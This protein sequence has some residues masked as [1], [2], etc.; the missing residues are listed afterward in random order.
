MKRIFILL[1]TVFLA[2]TVFS[3]VAVNNS[4]NAADAS[5]MLDVSSTSKGMLVPRMTTSQRT[6][7]SSPATGLLVFDTSTKSF[8][9]YDAG[10]SGWME[11]KASNNNSTLADADEDTKV[12]V[13]KTA[14]NDMISFSQ[15][16][17]EYF[18]MK[19]GR[20]NIENTGSSVF[21]GNLAGEHDNLSDN[22]NVFVGQLA[23]KENTSGDYNVAV[24]AVSFSTNTTG[25][26]NVALGSYALS[27]SPTASKNVAVGSYALYSDSADYNVALGYKALN[28]NTT[29][30]AN[31]AGGYKALFWNTSGKGNVAIGKE[32]LF[33]NSNNSYLVAIGDSALMNNYGDRN[34]AVGSKAMLY[35]TSGND[36]TAV[37]FNSLKNNVNGFHNTAIGDSS[38]YNTT[39]GYYNTAVGSSSLFTNNAGICN[40]AVGYQAMKTNFD[41]EK[42]VAV[43]YKSLYKNTSGNNNTAVGYRVMEKNTRGESNIAMGY[44]AMFYN[45]T[46][47]YNIAIGSNALMGGSAPNE[48]V[49]IGKD[50]ALGISTGEGNT[51]VGSLSLRN[52]GAGIGNVGIG[53]GA[54]YG[55]SSKN[56]NV[57]IGDSALFDGSGNN[58]TGIGSKVLRNN[59][60]SNN[61]AL[62][63]QAG[64]SN[65]TGSSNIFIGYQAGYNETGSNKLYI[66]NS[67]S[68]SPLIYGDFA[69]DTLKVF[70]TF[71]IKDRYSFP[72]ADGSANQVLK[73]NG[74]GVLSWSNDTGATEINGLSDGKTG[75]KSV[76]LGTDAGRV[77]DGSDNKNTAVGYD[78]LYNNTT[79]EGNTGLGEEALFQNTSGY[80]NVGIGVEANGNNQTGNFNT[81]IGYQAG[82]GT[83]SHNKSGCVLIGY[84]AGYNETGNNKLYIEN[85]NSSSPL[86]YGEF[87][88][89][90][91]TINGRLGIG[92]NAGTDSKLRVF[93][94]G[95]YA[96]YFT[97][98]YG[99][100]DTKVLKV[101]YT[102]PG[103]YDA[104]AVYGDATPDD[105]ANYGIGGHF[106]GNYIGLKAI[107]N[108]GSSSLTSYGI[109]A[110]CE[111]TAGTRYGIYGYASGSADH[112]YGVFGDAAAVSG[113]YALYCSGNGVYTGTWSQSSDEKLKKNIQPLNNALE[114]ISLLKPA[115]YYYRTSE[116]KSMNLDKGKQIGFVAQDL[117]KVFPELVSTVYHP[118]N[119]G[120]T[121]EFE[122]YKA[123]NYIGLIPVLTEAIQEQQQTISRLEK[124]T[125]MLL[126]R[127]QEIEQRLN[128]LESK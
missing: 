39:S 124:E 99:S 31:F 69:N 14:D 50:A 15:A 123:I 38:M 78:A 71:N 42:N 53:K 121:T 55:I 22:Y 65:N 83:S 64:Y 68:S 56:Y 36:N 93:H 120:K 84:Q 85:S 117:E 17:I 112:R 10:V 23:G 45:T 6:A 20:L 125:N 9:F 80:C 8:W 32:A 33:K 90:L 46:G 107:S 30:E 110:N 59:M 109:Y 108:S 126:N 51:A 76:F 98:Y 101:E 43:G 105:N 27:N 34:V 67:N 115:T 119:Q 52:V 47:D 19:N 18:Q 113:S 100:N 54:L 77:D 44:S 86:I 128:K 94:D 61:T 4:G 24:G 79:G 1:V 82:K 60:G 73:T 88:N 62:G 104:T 13:E 118:K 114:K 96:G 41:G 97:S 2:Q 12:E 7:I 92:T 37:G 95:L 11:I 16:G 75:G 116:F 74:N 106:K 35:N 111:G 5:A 81:I 49:A 57:G 89:D 103:T 26:E 58:N 102:S 63:Y 91:V 40:T 21:I 70:G 28:K 3:Q 122:S 87:D 127:L 25:S 66:E 48:N 72:V 29:G